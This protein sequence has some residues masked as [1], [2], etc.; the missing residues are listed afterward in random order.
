M[1]PRG[2]VRACAAPARGA[3]WHLRVPRPSDTAADHVTSTCLQVLNMSSV[4]RLRALGAHLTS[5]CTTTTHPT[6]VSENRRH[7]GEQADD[8]VGV[9]GWPNLG[10]P[11]PE[12]RHVPRLSPSS[13]A[14]STHLEEH[15][16]V[17][18]TTLR[19][20]LGLVST[21]LRPSHARGCGRLSL[22]ACS[23]KTNL[24]K[25]YPGSGR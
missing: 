14:V 18:V 21:P 11:A 1:T 7:H 2:A 10:L 23:R 15:G 3:A 25:G 9:L 6:A 20:T 16:F 5:T 19:V 8:A 22:L 17:G 24:K 13:A 12:Y 4:H